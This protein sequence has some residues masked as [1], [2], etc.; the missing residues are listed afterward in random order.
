MQNIWCVGS[1]VKVRKSGLFGTIK[2]VLIYYP[3]QTK[4][5]CEILMDDGSERVY[6][7]DTNGGPEGEIVL[8]KSAAM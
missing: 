8:I 1:T 2:Q 4:F 5:F 6:R 7:V 3:N